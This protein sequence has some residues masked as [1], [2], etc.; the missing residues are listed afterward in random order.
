MEILNYQVLDGLFNDKL[1]L[2]VTDVDVRRLRDDRSE[3]QLG[4]DVAFVAT[5]KFRASNTAIKAL[6]DRLAA[7]HLAAGDE[8]LVIGPDAE[9]RSDKL[10]IDEDSVALW[11]KDHYDFAFLLNGSASDAF[12]KLGP[13]RVATEIPADR[14]SQITLP[15]ITRLNTAVVKDD[16]IDVDVQISPRAPSSSPTKAA[17]LVLVNDFVVERGPAKLKAWLE[18]NVHPDLF[19]DLVHHDYLI[20]LAAPGKLQLAV[21]FEPA[22]VQ[23][24]PPTKPGK[25]HTA[26]TKPK[27]P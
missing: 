25:D 21:R 3:I 5:A 16:Y 8:L 2:E 11:I 27:Q 1:F 6:A 17:N 13:I 26:P 9:L 23:Q 7:S 19:D 24:E 20:D 12:R 22:G 4:Q 10:E 14:P 18:L 15:W